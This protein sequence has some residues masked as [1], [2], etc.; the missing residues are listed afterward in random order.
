MGGATEAAKV[1]L[2]HGAYVLAEAEHKSTPR[3]WAGTAAEYED[4]VELLIS[5]GG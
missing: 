4:V 2:A 5:H 1:L 3:Q